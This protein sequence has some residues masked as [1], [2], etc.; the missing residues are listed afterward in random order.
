MNVLV[1]GSSGFIGR[2]LTRH[3]KK[4]QFTVLGLDYQAADDGAFWN[5]DSLPSKEQVCTWL[6]SFGLDGFIKYR[7]GS[8]END[9]V[10]ES[11]LEK[12]QGVQVIVHLASQSHVDRSIKSP[13]QFVDDNVNG[14]LELYELARLLPNLLKIIQFSTDEVVA[15]I[16]EGSAKEKDI[17]RCGSVYSAT[18]G[19]QELL[20]QAYVKTYRLPIIIS[21]CVNVFGPEQS[22]EKFIPTIASKIISG[23]EIPVYGSGYQT[24]EWVY[25]DHV[26][27][28]V[29]WMALNSYI[30]DGT[31][32]HITGTKEIPNLV[33]IEAIKG[34]LGKDAKVSHVQDRPGH[35]VRYSLDAGD[36]HIVWDMPKYGGNFIEDLKT[37][38]SW[39]IGRT[40]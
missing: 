26:V 6:E 15:C 39:Y 4:N 22:L 35:D 19:A 9:S 25:V 23:E 24:R 40:L 38:L 13:R 1:T 36:S 12:L 29:N 37:T 30:P 18:K 33:M 14:T 20:A 8:Y 21:R 31:I 11:V 27:E 32:L 7:L 5:K 28:C 17:F 2:H 3:L 16:D 34:I 10:R